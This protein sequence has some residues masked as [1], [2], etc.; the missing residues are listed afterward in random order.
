MILNIHNF[1][2]GV[3]KM[4]KPPKTS[5]P[6]RFGI[7][8]AANI[9]PIALLQPVQTHPDAVVVS[10]AA[11]DINKARAQAAKYSIPE[12]YGS[13]DELLETSDVD[14]IYIPLPNGLHAEWAIKSMKAGK[15]VLIEKPIASNADQVRQIQS[16]AKSIIDSGRYG[17]IV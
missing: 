16:C 5:S 3:P 4:K 15:H 12:A 7:L 2:S 10:I 17:N 14:A 1:F 11:R 8:S 13:Y 6:V 9:N